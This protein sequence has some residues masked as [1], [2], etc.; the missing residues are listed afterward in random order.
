MTVANEPTTPSEYLCAARKLTGGLRLAMLASFNFE[1]L[2]PYLAVQGSLMGAPMSVSSGPFGQ[3]E[4]PLLD[5]NSEFWQSRPQ[6]G[7][8]FARLLDVEPGL[9]YEAS[10]ESHL[11]R[12]AALRARVVGL[13]RE[14][15][16]RASAPLLVANF[17]LDRSAADLFDASQPD[18]LCHL[19]SAEN[20]TLAEELRTIPDAHVFDYAGVVS[21]IG[22]SR[23][24]DRKMWILA[25]SPASHE[26]KVALAR[27]VARGVRAVTRAAL[28]CIVVD[29]DNTLW[30]GVIGDDGLAG[31]KLSDDGAGAPF[32]ELQ[33][34]LK[35]LRSRGFLLAIVSKNNEATAL[36]AIEKHPEMV[37]RRND[38]A[39]VSISWNPKPEGLREIARSL[40]I[41]LDA[42]LLVDDNPVE[43]AAVR[44]A[45]PAVDVLE[46]PHDPMGFAE[47]VLSAP[48]LDRPRLA[49]EDRNRAAMV[50]ADVVRDSLKHQSGSIGEFLSDLRMVAQVGVAGELQVERIHQLVSKTNQW[51]LTTRR[52]TL[53]QVRRLA[54]SPDADVACLRLEDRYGD[55][56]LVC[57]GI[58]DQRQDAVEIDT[59][60]MSC[61]V[62]GRQ[63]E[64]AFL[65]YLTELARQRGAKR[66][67]GWFLPTAKNEPVKEFYPERGFTV[68][69]KSAEGQLWQRS[70]DL[71]WPQW[72]PHIARRDA[73][74]P[75]PTPKN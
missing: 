14:F 74:K 55:L 9:S 52:H 24:F 19:I 25:K 30:G 47:A 7:L 66:L 27:D 10:D 35:G 23:F 71:T 70:L 3:F 4:Q 17:C 45:L 60:L 28:K 41:G 42:L 18:G 62:M 67:C 46:L 43:R 1:L 33:R 58:L 57:V 21:R 37:L 36:E 5:D 2:R 6:A 29:L 54:A 53:D 68:V 13:A 26:G 50:A 59:L 12:L 69:S 56:G 61:R 51:N 44:A 16:T 38:F 8:I 22:T 34:C 11:Q 63:V 31:I 72:P 20:R 64:D 65:A 73:V 32:K 15:R 48:G 40:N 39:A 49:A 75:D